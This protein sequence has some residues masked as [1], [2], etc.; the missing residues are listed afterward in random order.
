[1]G[2]RRGGER[3]GVSDMRARE[4]AAAQRQAER[5]RQLKAREEGTGAWALRYGEYGVLESSPDGLTVQCHCCGKWVKGLGMHGWMEHA[6]LADEYREQ[7][8]LMAKTGLVSPD[9]RQRYAAVS[10]S[11]LASVDKAARRRNLL[12]ARYRR[13]EHPEPY[14]PRREEAKALFTKAS[15]PDAAWRSMSA[16][17]VEGQTRAKH[18]RQVQGIVPTCAWCQDAMLQAKRAYQNTFCSRAC[19]RRAITGLDTAV[20]RKGRATLVAIH[21]KRRRNTEYAIDI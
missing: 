10:A 2:P 1:M 11:N 17:G 19:Y 4:R 12:A 20:L 8:G 9:T 6:I 7:F 3:E 16:K 13:M 5:E 14:R 18:I 15:R 21:A